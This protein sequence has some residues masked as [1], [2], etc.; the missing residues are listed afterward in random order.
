M[1]ELEIQSNIKI[2]A[3][4][5]THKNQLEE[6]LALF[7]EMNVTKIEPIIDENVNDKDSLGKYQTLAVLRDLFI[8]FKNSGDTKVSIEIGKCNSNCYPDCAVFN[9]TGNTSNKNFA[10]V[11][12]K[13]N[14]IIKKLHYCGLFSTKDN[15]QKKPDV[16][17]YINALKKEVEM[18]GGDTSQYDSEDTREMLKHAL[19][20]GWNVG[21]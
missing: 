9:L 13:E 1:P 7:A 20:M 15:I 17:M 12:D 8:D 19:N 14:G 3:L 16:D 5:D 6:I 11:L 10:F 2:D 21:K 18:E 4:S